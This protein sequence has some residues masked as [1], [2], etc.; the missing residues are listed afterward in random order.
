MENSYNRPAF[1]PRS[2]F[3]QRP[4]L[5]YL[6][7]INVAVFLAI[8]IV[9][10]PAFLMNPGSSGSLVGTIVNFL[11]VPAYIPA[12]FH[13]PWSLV[14]YMFLHE[15]VWHI[16]FN[17]LWLF[18]FGKIFLEYLSQSKLWVV[19]IL[20]GL[21][22]G[23]IYILAFNTFPV[24]QSQVQLSFALG[25]SASV[26]AVVT[27]ISF[28]VPNYSMYL[29][30]FGRVKIVYLAIALFVID[31]FMIPSGNAG[32]HIA[33]IGGALFGFFYAR[34][35]LPGG[36]GRLSLLNDLTFRL[37]KIFK[38]GKRASDPVADRGRP[39][40]DDDYNF[41]KAERQKRIDQIL[42]KISKGGYDSLTREEKDFLFK[43]SNKS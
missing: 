41:Q 1:D 14:T 38:P 23:L 36:I 10:V 34:F 8:Q 29:L 39:L 20:G 25:A 33:H 12:L 27:A 42:E 6:V 18:W 13:H 24:F 11:A 9:R 17:M 5:T 26:M 15:D 22:G 43:S 30:F 7:L 19:Y 3:T 21:S 31:F 40:N 37:K 4:S 28:Y 16:L 32:G 2:F 35:I